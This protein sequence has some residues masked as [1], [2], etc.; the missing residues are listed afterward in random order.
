MYTDLT[1]LIPL[2]L[3]VSLK[4]RRLK[5]SKHS[6]VSAVHVLWCGTY[7]SVAYFWC[8]TISHSSLL[9]RS[10]PYNIGVTSVVTL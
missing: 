5:L 4:K 6:K 1:L 7:I 8:S 9:P 3:K 10:L 2:K